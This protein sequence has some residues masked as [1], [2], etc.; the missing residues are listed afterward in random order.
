MLTEGGYVEGVGYNYYS[1]LG[2]GSSTDRTTAV[3]TKTHQTNM[4]QMQNIFQQEKTQ[5]FISRK[6][7]SEG[8]P[9]GMYVIGRNDYGQ[10]FTGNT[11]RAYYA[12]EVEKKEK[13]ILTMALTE[14]QTGLI[15]DTKGNV[16]TVGYNGQGQIGNGTYENTTEKVFISQVKLN[17]TPKSNK[18][19][20]KQETQ[21]K[22]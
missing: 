21:E 16:Y 12:T 1:Q 9:Q 5:V 15:V 6:K 3:Y 18:L 13:D 19:Q 2:D 4:Y 20:K 22:K 8:N 14:G 7:D 17:T 10:L 11:T